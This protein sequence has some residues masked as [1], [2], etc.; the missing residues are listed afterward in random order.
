MSA[1]SALAVNFHNSREKVENPII[2]QRDI[3]MSCLVIHAIC[4]TQRLFT[5][6][7]GVWHLLQCRRLF[8][9]VSISHINNVN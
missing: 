2:S 6:D 7:S 1:V 4:L 9:G 5:L 3:V 8:Y